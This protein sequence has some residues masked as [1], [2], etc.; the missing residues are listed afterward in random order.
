MR[1]CV[2]AVMETV[3]PSQLM[4]S[5][6]HRMW[7]S[8]ASD[9]FASSMPGS[10]SS[11]ADTRQ[12]FGERQ[13]ENSL[14]TQGVV[15]HDTAWM[16][17]HH[18]TD[19]CSVRPQGMAAERLERALC[20]SLGDECYEFPFVGH[21]QGV[22]TE[23]LTRTLHAGVDGYLGLFDGDAHAAACGNLAQHGAQ[24]SA[25]RITQHVNLGA[26]F[27]QAGA[28]LVKRGRVAS[29]LAFKRQALTL[30]QDGHAMVAERAGND[31]GVTRTN[32]GRAELEPFG[33]QS[34]S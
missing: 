2:A 29:E 33:N 10:F 24:S 3:S 26:G 6:I 12:R 15:E 7:T 9:G 5:D 8:W 19:A 30:R 14:A 34:D 4:P 22:E 25:R 31:D 13:V 21:Q 23:D 27:E 11:S 18:E 17:G 1:G 20:S 32:P 28:K 16:L